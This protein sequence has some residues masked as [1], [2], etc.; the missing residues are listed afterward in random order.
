MPYVHVDVSRDG[1][2]ERV[3]AHSSENGTFIVRKGGG[4]TA[5][6]I[7]YGGKP[8]HHIV[9]LPPALRCMWCTCTAHTMQTRTMSQRV[10]HVPVHVRTA[11]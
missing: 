5:L 2:A 6:C 11:H 3:E 8:T 10:A 1:A 4:K 7:M 9:R